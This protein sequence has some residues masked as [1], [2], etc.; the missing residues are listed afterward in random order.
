MVNSC[1]HLKE[2]NASIF[3]VNHSKKIYSLFHDSIIFVLYLF[4]VVCNIDTSNAYCK[5]IYS[6]LQDACETL[7]KR[8]EPFKAANPKGKWADWVK[9][10][11]FE[12]VSLS[13]TGFYRWGK[14]F[15]L[16]FKHTFKFVY[17][18]E[19]FRSFCSV[20]GIVSKLHIT[21]ILLFSD[22]NNSNSSSSSSSNN[23]FKPHKT[24]M[25]SYLL[26]S[27]T[28][29]IG[30]DMSKNEGKPFR[31]FT[32]GAACSEVE[33]DCLTGDHQVTSQLIS[34]HTVILNIMI[35]RLQIL[36]NQI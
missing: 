15:T 27:S 28:P 22:C 32:Y 29:G 5:C 35:M 26:F 16:R 17:S 36:Q 12:R 24:N 2:R 9:A 4:E 30:Y 23:S 14:L 3:R 10:A 7:L 8:L 6:V 1:R 33:I 13:A 34:D 25:Y 31:Y 21:V 19:F 18:L 20:L 11:Y